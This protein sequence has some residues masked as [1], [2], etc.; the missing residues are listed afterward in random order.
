MKILVQ[1]LPPPPK[2][3]I[4]VKD[5]EPNNL[6]G[7]QFDGQRYLLSGDARGFCWVRG[8]TGWGSN[9]PKSFATFIAETLA[10]GAKVVVLE[11]PEEIVSWMS[12][13]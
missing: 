7:M 10:M 11:T 8:T 4:E 1:Q 13:Q 9:Y 5:Y 2:A 6:L 3:V 12:G